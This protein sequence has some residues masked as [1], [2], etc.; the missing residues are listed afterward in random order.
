MLKEKM[1]GYGLEFKTFLDTKE[2]NRY[3]VFRIPK[4]DSSYSYHTFVEVEAKQAARECGAEEGPNDTTW[5]MWNSL[6]SQQP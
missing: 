3:L 5:S 6:W 4:G 1:A 2:H